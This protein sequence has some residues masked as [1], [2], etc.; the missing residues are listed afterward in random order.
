MEVNPRTTAPAVDPNEAAKEQAQLLETYRDVLA[1]RPIWRRM[2]TTFWNHWFEILGAGVVIAVLTGVIQS[3]FQFVVMPLQKQSNIFVIV[4]ALVG[5]LYMVVQVQAQNG[6]IR[7]LLQ[8]M[9][10]DD[11]PFGLFL[12]DPKRI[13]FSAIGS[14]VYVLVVSVGYVLLFVPGV[15]WSVQYRYVLYLIVDKKVSVKQAFADSA[16]M[17]NGLKWRIVALDARILFMAIGPLLLVL[18]LGLGILYGYTISASWT[19]PAL[20]LGSVAGLVYVGYLLTIAGPL[21]LLHYVVY[22]LLSQRLPTAA[23]SV[24]T[25]ADE[26]SMPQSAQVPVDAG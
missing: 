7:Y 3:A 12:A 10:H 15:I 21:G 26:S 22:E 1:F 9:R 11:A 14:L 24:Q 19:S 8:L 5:I 25:S 23:E 6:W 13:L 4:S 18:F 20:I 17:T 16:A 2:W